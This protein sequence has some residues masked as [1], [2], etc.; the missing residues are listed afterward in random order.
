[1]A[2]G[3]A[4]LVLWVFLTIYGFVTVPVSHVGEM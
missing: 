4:V 3:A 2:F 1:M